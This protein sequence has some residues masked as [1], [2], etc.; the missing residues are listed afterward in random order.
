M[1]YQIGKDPPG[2]IFE[3]PQ[4]LS[5]IVSIRRMKIFKDPDVQDFYR[6]L[7]ILVITLFLSN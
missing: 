5:K 7:R 2:L 6:S 3:G 4:R 1:E